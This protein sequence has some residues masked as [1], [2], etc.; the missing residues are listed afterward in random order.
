[1]P[2]AKAAAVSG[3]GASR[4]AWRT[5]R[6]SASTASV[7]ARSTSV[8]VVSLMPEDA[9]ADIGNAA[10]GRSRRCE[11]GTRSR[12]RQVPIGDDGYGC[13][14]RWVMM[15]QH[16]QLDC[17][18]RARVPSP[19]SAHRRMS[20]QHPAGGLARVVAVQWCPRLPY[21]ARCPG[22]PSVR[23]MAGC[24][25]E[26][27]PGQAVR[28]ERDAVLLGVA[29][30]AGRDRRGRGS[31]RPSSSSGLPQAQQTILPTRPTF[32]PRCR[33]EAVETLRSGTGERVG[34]P[35]VRPATPGR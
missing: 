25:G 24:G 16:G 28:S 14:S 7:I 20:S 22:G 23:E 10:V 13:G 8:S 26:A 29:A 31:G 17:T 9:V 6:R 19:T 30:R 21:P 18:R 27:R 15:D 1:M 35:W 5:A 12:E 32:R 11:G 2:S 3:V 4:R 33:A 34:W